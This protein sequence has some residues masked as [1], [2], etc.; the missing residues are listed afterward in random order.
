MKHIFY[1]NYDETY[2]K[3]MDSRGFLDEANHG[4]APVK[5]FFFQTWATV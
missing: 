2:V 5:I 3:S 4:E 1:P